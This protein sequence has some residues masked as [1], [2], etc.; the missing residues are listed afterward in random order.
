MLIQTVSRLSGTSPRLILIF[1]GWGMDPK[2]F[3][4]LGRHGYDTAVVWDYADA[5]PLPLPMLGR[6]SEI[7]VLA[8]SFGVPYAARFIAANEDSLPITRCVAVNGTLHPVDDSRGIPHTIFDGTLEALSERTL[9]KFRRRM[10]GGADAFRSFMAHAPERTI[11]SLAA[12]LRRVKADGSAPD[13]SFDAVYISSDDRIIP[14]ASQMVAWGSHHSVTMLP[15]HAHLTSLQAII[16]REF[17]DKELVSRSFGSH[18][19]TYDRCATV[20]QQVARNLADRFAASLTSSKPVVEFGAGTGMLSRCLGS[21]ANELRLYDIAPASPAVRQADAETEIAAM[22]AAEPQGVAGIVSASTIQW[23]NS[24]VRFIRRALRALPGGAVMAL[25]SFTPLTYR[26]LLP[27]QSIRPA[28]IAPES[29]GTIAETLAGE[30][31]IAPDYVVEAGEPQL[32]TFDDTRSLVDHIRAT[33]VNATQ[34]PDIA[35][36]RA[37]MRSGIRSLTYQPLFFTATRL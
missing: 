33:G 34:S 20:Q 35:A 2:P 6:Y 25:S 32:L 24:P 1:A 16:D 37:L 26:E 9:D 27:F 8:W 23:F 28:Y 31:V 30:G 10:A 19:D 17:R 11:E 29:L 14:T 3:E 13:P 4:S 22:T 36:A 15:G 7:C 12:E 18:G 5:S 21:L